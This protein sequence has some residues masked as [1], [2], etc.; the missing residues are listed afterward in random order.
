MCGRWKGFC[1]KFLCIFFNKIVWEVG[2]F[3]LKIFEVDKIKIN[4]LE[5][6]FVKLYFLGFFDFIV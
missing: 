1:Y 5:L 2:Y 3:F 6:F 4:G